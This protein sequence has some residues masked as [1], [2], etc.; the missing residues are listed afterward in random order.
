MTRPFVLT[1]KRNQPCHTDLPPK[2]GKDNAATYKSRLGITLFLIYSAVYFGFV[3]INSVSPQLMGLPMLGMNLAVLYGF[4]L[5][6]FALALA[7]AYNGFCTRA[8]ERLNHKI[9]EVTHCQALLRGRRHRALGG[10]RDR[11][12][13]CALLVIFSSALVIALFARGFRTAPD[14][15]GEQAYHSFRTIPFSVMTDG[16]L[17][18]AEDGAVIP[19]HLDAE[20][21]RQE[22]L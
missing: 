9:K 19:A 18:L 15:G 10:E 6:A 14:H 11:F 17:M 13:G 7:F 12:C 16:G 22:V 21:F 20:S 2:W 5:I 4:G 8:E 3:L 1:K